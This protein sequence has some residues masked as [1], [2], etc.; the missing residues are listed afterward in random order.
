M[1]SQAYSSRLGDIPN[2]KERV[3]PT[4]IFG[5]KSAPLLSFEEAVHY[6][7]QDE[8]LSECEF[9]FSIECALEF[10]Q[11]KAAEQKGTNLT[12]DEIAAIYLY[13]LPS[14]FYDILNLRLREP[15]RQRLSP[16]F[17]FIKLLLNGLYKLPVISSKTVYRGV[18][19]NLAS[20]YNK[21]EKKVWWAFSSTTSH[22]EVLQNE[23][24]LGKAGDRTKF[25]IDL[26]CGFD[27]TFF[28]SLPTEKEVLLIP[29]TCLEVVSILDNGGGLHEIQM[30]QLDKK[31]VIDFPP[32]FPISSSPLLLSPSSVPLQRQHAT[33]LLISS[34]PPVPPKP[35]VRH[36]CSALPEN[37]QMTQTEE[38]RIYFWNVITRESTWT[39]PS[40]ETSS[41]SQPA[42]LK[43]SLVSQQQKQKQPKEPFLQFKETKE[44]EEKEENQA[45]HSFLGQDFCFGSSQQQL[46]KQKQKVAL[47]FS[48]FLQFAIPQPTLFFFYSDP[49]ARFIFF[50]RS[51]LLCC[52][53][54][55][56]HDWFLWKG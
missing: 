5:I 41:I 34:P 51:G 4:P 1:F 21:G 20:L 36:S 26:L 43:P 9:E 24:F 13:T 31:G 6:S 2:H 7:K 53:R 56:S 33:S 30:R 12:F 45:I 40:T 54:C 39:I 32:P 49:F 19:Q 22:V 46:R 23:Q 50:F 18:K 38:G 48:S 44:K 52:R 37:W 15:E 3:K 17:S 8:R 25:N 55:C 47:L 35:K 42:L 28:S 14:P 11:E 10:A 29:G 27:I 16:H